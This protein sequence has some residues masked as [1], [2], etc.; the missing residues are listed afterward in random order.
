MDGTRPGVRDEHG[1]R[2]LGAA[3][4]LVVIGLVVTLRLYE[5]RAWVRQLGYVALAAVILQG[6]MGGLRVT[7]KSTA[8]AIVHGC[9][10]QAF[11]C[12]TIALA[13][14]TSSA[15]PGS[16]PFG[17]VDVRRDRALRIWTAALAAAVYG[18]L[19]L[20]A[21]VR[22]SGSTTTA[23][24]HIFG[25]LVVGGCL[26]QAAQHVFARPES[27]RPIGRLIMALF[28]LFGLQLFL[29][30]VTYVL[31]MPMP[32]RNPTTLLRIYEPTVHMA[33]GALILGIA[34]AAAFRAHTLTAPAAAGALP[35]VAVA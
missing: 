8:L 26:I 23:V 7:E 18:Q 28:A 10:A 30:V 11:L 27:E 14:V 13:M 16:T 2:L 31:V 19:I 22:H 1:H 15:W 21:L 32:A 12:L 4:G 29:G 34:F 20:G 9:F 3:V 17:G 33:V 5:R 25:A 35:E 24:L 6:V